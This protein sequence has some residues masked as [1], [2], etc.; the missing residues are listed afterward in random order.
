MGSFDH[1]RSLDRAQVSITEPHNLARE[2]AY[3]IDLMLENCCG[4]SLG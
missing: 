4:V 3:K 1:K 2:A